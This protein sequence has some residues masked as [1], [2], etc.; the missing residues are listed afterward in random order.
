MP[1]NFVSIIYIFLLL[2]V[3]QCFRAIAFWQY[4]DEKFSH[5]RFRPFGVFPSGHQAKKGTDTPYKTSR[6]KNNCIH[7]TRLL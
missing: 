7:N 3:Y 1:D 6:P 2:K 4:C 5:A